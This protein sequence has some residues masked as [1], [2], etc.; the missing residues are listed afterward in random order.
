MNL[1]DN[2]MDEIVALKFGTKLIFDR[3]ECQRRV[4][5]GE[6][7]QMITRAHMELMSR[8]DL[9]PQWDN[10]AKAPTLFRVSQLE[11]THEGRNP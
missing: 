6:N 10:A 5:E 3:Y 8:A 7:F 4:L 2:A 1:T 9:G 11:G